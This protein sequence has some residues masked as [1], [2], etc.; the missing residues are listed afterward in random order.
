MKRKVFFYILVAL[1]LY[2]PSV[3]Q[4]CPKF[5]VYKST[6]IDIKGIS[7]KLKKNGVSVNENAIGSILID[8]K[9]V[10]ASVELQR[11]D[12]YQKTLCEQLRLI[13]SDSLRNIRRTEYIMALVNMMAIAQKPDSLLGSRV[14]KLEIAEEERLN[15][16]KNLNQ[17]KRT[18]PEAQIILYI[19]RDGDIRYFINIMNDVPFTFR[20]YLSRNDGKSMTSQSLVI[21]P[22]P[23]LNPNKQRQWIF[24]TGRNINDPQLPQEPIFKVNLRFRY[25]SIYVEEVN[26]EGLSKDITQVYTIDRKALTAVEINN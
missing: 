22:G 2:K 1:S 18:P 9:Y 5:F 19:S 25:S 17:L 8:P 10:Q 6:K 21:G 20:A 26:A 4:K 13:K 15:N 12:L 3:S 16:E 24:S 14:T 23:I 7:I 11:L